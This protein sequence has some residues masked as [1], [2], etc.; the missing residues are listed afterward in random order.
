MTSHGRNFT[1]D[2]PVRRVTGE[3]IQ[4]RNYVRYLQAKFTDIYGL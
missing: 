1:A 2:E 3:P 4:S